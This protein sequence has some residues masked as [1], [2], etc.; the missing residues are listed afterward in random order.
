MVTLITARDELISH[1]GWWVGLG[2]GGGYPEYSKG[3]CVSRA[4]VFKNG[5]PGVGSDSVRLSY[6]IRVCKQTECSCLKYP[7]SHYVLILPSPISDCGN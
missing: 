6:G 5:G 2:P 3:A 7:N 1:W 4:T